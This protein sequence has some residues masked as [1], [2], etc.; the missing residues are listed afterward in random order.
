ME[1]L[2]QTIESN[3]YVLNLKYQQDKH[4]LGRNVQ[5][6]TREVRRFYHP[7]RDKL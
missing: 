2:V 6:Q 1:V 5:I 7:Y 3:I 4:Y